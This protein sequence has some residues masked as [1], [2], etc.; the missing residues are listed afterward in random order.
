MSKKSKPGDGI[1]AQGA[2]G[3][4]PG[5]TDKQSAAFTI[6]NLVSGVSKLMVWK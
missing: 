1:F 2:K 5:A 4:S 3:M 6:A